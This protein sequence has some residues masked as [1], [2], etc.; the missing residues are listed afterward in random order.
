MHEQ[1]EYGIA[2]HWLY[3][4]SGGSSASKT[5]DA[6]RLD[7]QINWLK[8][9]LD[10]AASDEITDAKE[11]LHSLKVDLLSLIHI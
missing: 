6:Q 3:K 9:S 11:Y 4:K 2:A 1:A 7:D 5:N 8:H 10:W